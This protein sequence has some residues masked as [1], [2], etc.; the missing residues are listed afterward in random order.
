M[1]R[2]SNQRGKRSDTYLR[3]S[4]SYCGGPCP[5]GVL[6]W[7]IPGGS[8]RKGYLFQASGIYKKLS[9]WELSLRCKKRT[10]F[11]LTSFSSW[12]LRVKEFPWVLHVWS[13]LKGH[14][15]KWMHHRFK[16]IH[17][18]INHFQFIATILRENTQI[19]TPD[20]GSFP[21]LK[22]PKKNKIPSSKCQ[23]KLPFG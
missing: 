10:R 14:S 16:H 8:A 17:P 20:N 2:N 15:T 19:Q 5:W 7:P 4:M 18:T 11:A 6:H 1:V 22:I 9:T 21:P 13:S 12:F 23:R 3:L